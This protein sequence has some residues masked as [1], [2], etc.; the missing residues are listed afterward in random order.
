MTNSA[1]RL[2]D[3]T[4]REKLAQ[5]AADDPKSIRADVANAA[6]RKTYTHVASFFEDLSHHGCV[7]GM[8]S[9]LVAYADTHRFFDAHYNEIEELRQELEEN[10]GEPLKINGDFKNGLAWFAFEQIAFQI[11]E[12]LEF[13]L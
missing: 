5:I 6:R 3:K 8:I 11:A 2:S 12:E 9:G 4:C 1:H 13:D 10:I 7:S